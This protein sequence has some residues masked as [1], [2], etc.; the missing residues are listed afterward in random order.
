[1]SFGYAVSKKCKKCGRVFSVK[2]DTL[3]FGN[4]NFDHCPFCGSDGITISESSIAHS[5]M[6]Q[7]QKLDKMEEREF[8]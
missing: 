6:E 5:M 8:Y 3:E 2:K 1:M 4:K 7:R